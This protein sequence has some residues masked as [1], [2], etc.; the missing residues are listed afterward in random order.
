MNAM[1][2]TCRDWPAAAEPAPITRELAMSLAV[3]GMLLAY[4]REHRE[5]LRR[6]REVAATRAD[7]APAPLSA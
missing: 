1:T 3:E 6:E 4:S 5:V 2:G 7:P